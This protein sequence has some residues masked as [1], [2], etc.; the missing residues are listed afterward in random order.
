MYIGVQHGLNMDRNFLKR[1]KL[2]KSLDDSELDALI[3]HLKLRKYAKH[4]L[5]ISEGAISN[6]LYLIVNGQ[7]KVFLSDEDGKEVILA[8]ME[9]GDY[10]GEIGLLD[11]R[12]RTA[13][14]TTL[15]DCQLA[16]MGKQDFL[17]CMRAH[18]E[19][20]LSILKTMLG[21]IRLLDENVKSLALMD[22]YGRVARVL[23]NMAGA[24][25]RRLYC[26]KKRSSF[27]QGRVVAR[28]LID[29]RTT[30]SFAQF[31]YRILFQTGT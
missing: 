16:V 3:P 23:L 26:S 24:Q 30:P 14:I 31:I 19:V 8:V 29:T 9:A 11:D 2:F 25:I 17:N 12:P 1:V 21:Y 6:S 20:V 7:V 10:F 28:R 4:H 27:S 18:P 5:V 22:V 13:N 15:K